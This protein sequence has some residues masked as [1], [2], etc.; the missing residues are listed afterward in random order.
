MP[1]PVLLNSAGNPEPSADIQR[2]LRQV[3]PGLSLR[4]NPEDRS[5]WMV[6]M[7][8]SDGDPRWEMAQRQEIA[9][10]A[11]YDIVGRL[12]L[13]CGVDEAPAYLERS[14]RTYPREAVKSLT[15]SV[16]RFN[17]GVLAET[18]DKAIAEVLDAPDPASTRKVTGRRR[19]I[20]L[21]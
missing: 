2:R 3:H 5:R 16:A 4:F 1:N 15:Q 19:R 13:D 11:T 6:T 14:L 12:P 10:D 8:W 21:P 17:A 20:T 7:E 18:A 9:R